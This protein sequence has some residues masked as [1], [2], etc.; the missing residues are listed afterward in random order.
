MSREAGGI[1]AFIEQVWAKVVFF[2]SI[3]SGILGYTELAK[4]NSGL[5]T[6][7]LL[8]V[9]LAGLL[10]SCIFYGKNYS[11]VVTLR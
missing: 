10:L 8:G 7:V 6:L 3:I 9:A 5:F 11:Y 2:F 1:F 4:G